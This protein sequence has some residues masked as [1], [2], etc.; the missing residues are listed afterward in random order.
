[1]EPPYPAT[2]EIDDLDPISQSSITIWLKA[3]IRAFLGYLVF[4]R[5]SVSASLPLQHRYA[6]MQYRPT[7]FFFTASRIPCPPFPLSLNR[8]LSVW[9]TYRGATLRHILPPQ[10]TGK[11]PKASFNRRSTPVGWVDTHLSRSYTV[12]IS[13][14]NIALKNATFGARPDREGRG[15]EAALGSPSPPTGNHNKPKA[16]ATRSFACPFL[17]HNPGRYQA[18]KCNGP[19]FPTVFRVK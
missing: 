7:S 18:T 17:K 6:Y 11:H 15:G 3:I 9:K 16:A 4:W 10:A 19:G 12:N 13:E 14:I 5:K 8:N 1:M 2:L